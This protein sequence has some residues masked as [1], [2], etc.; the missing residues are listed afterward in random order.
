MGQFFYKKILYLYMSY[1]VGNFTDNNSRF[2]SAADIGGRRVLGM[3]GSLTGYI[4]T[5]D[6]YN[7]DY[8]SGGNTS[9]RGYAKKSK[10]NIPDIIKWFG[11]M[12]SI[13]AGTLLLKS[14]K[15]DYKKI[16]ASASSLGKGFNLDGLKNAFSKVKGFKLSDLKNKLGPKISSFKPGDAL[17]DFG[18]KIK[19][20][21]KRP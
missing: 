1:R 17:K 6:P 18:T 19:N 15:I 2:H 10:F 13:T 14:G 8:Y 7:K 20:L 11:I 5:G 4:R 9:K 3:G 16:F 12:G 21:V